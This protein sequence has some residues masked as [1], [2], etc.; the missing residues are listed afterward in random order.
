MQRSI[1]RHHQ[2]ADH[3]KPAADAERS[4]IF[5]FGRDKHQER[6]TEKSN[7]KTKE[8]MEEIDDARVG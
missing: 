4:R 8:A 7:I 5:H 1:D 6:S 2:V 3:D